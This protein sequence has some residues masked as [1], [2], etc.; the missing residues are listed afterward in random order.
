[1]T[2]S[3]CLLAN[4]TCASYN[5]K[6]PPQFQSL[7]MDSVAR[8][9]SIGWLIRSP[10]CQ[11]TCLGALKGAWFSGRFLVDPILS[12]STFDIICRCK[13]M[14][15]LSRI[16]ALSIHQLKMLLLMTTSGNKILII[17]CKVSRFSA[18]VVNFSQVI[19]T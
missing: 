15:A 4:L 9:P 1:M 14:M 16:K 3:M 8:E 2:Y 6:L 13:H 11:G 7:K 18:V 19:S 12:L 10:S 17:A 5:S